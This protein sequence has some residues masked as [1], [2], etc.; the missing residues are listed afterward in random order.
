MLLAAAAQFIQ[1]AWAVFLSVAMGFV[2][3]KREYASHCFLTR[4]ISHV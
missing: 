4:D 3:W 2:I 1:R